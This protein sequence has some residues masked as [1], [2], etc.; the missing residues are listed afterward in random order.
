MTQS[1]WYV[2]SHATQQREGPLSLSTIHDK[3]KAGSIQDNTL[4]FQS[5]WTDWKP[6][7][8][9]KNEFQQPPPPPN[10]TPN[11]GTPIDSDK[12]KVAAS[13][14]TRLD[15]SAKNT[16]TRLEPER[17]KRSKRVSV[18]GQV[19]VHN[20]DDLVFAQSANISAEGIFVKTEKP[21]FHI[22]ETLKLTCRVKAISTPFNAEAQVV[23][24]ASGPTEPS[25]YGLFFTSI[26]PEISQRI[27]ELTNSYKAAN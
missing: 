20:N 22:G 16:S 11:P 9:C 18:Y 7:S 13:P 19:I 21:I 3:I 26:K 5:G 1:V 15:F 8:S 24:R 27:R 25:G 6:Y 2:Y 23:R 14:V 12:T 17:Q 4:I 10:A